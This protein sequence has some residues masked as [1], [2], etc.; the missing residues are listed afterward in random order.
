MLK[1][2]LP[3]EKKTL[4]YANKNSMSAKCKILLPH[5]CEQVCICDEVI[6]VDTKRPWHI[7][8]AA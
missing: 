2:N 7:T 5:D 6:C 3:P 8:T 1:I 4:Y